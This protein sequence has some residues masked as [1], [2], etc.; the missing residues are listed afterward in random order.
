[1]TAAQQY[2]HDSRVYLLNFLKYIGPWAAIISAIIGYMFAYEWIDTPARSRVVESVIVEVN[3]NT[4]TLV[5]MKA[6]T[7]IIS[8][9]NAVTAEKLR[10]INEKVKSTNERFLLIDSKLDQLINTMIIRR[11]PE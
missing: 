8:R 7:G 3:K 9:N 10:S 4:E 6:V 11:R 5:E 1:M 2:A